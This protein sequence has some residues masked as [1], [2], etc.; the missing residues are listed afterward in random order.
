M[1]VEL[2]AYVKQEAI[3]PRVYV[4]RNGDLL[5]GS[6]HYQIVGNTEIEAVWWAVTIYTE[7]FDLLPDA[8]RHSFTSLNTLPMAGSRLFVIDIAPEWPEGSAN[9]LPCRRGEPF[10]LV[11]RFYRPGAQVVGDPD[12]L[13]VPNVIRVL[14]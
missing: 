1:P 14:D 2:S 12:G 8:E 6:A 9:W 7:R 3:Y 11:W 13:E 4:D 5:D 10:N